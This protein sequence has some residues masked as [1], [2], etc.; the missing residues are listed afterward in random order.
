M[1]DVTTDMWHQYTD[2][3]ASPRF[4]AF[5]FGLD[6]IGFVGCGE[7]VA[8]TY[9]DTWWFNPRMTTTTA[10]GIAETK[11]NALQFNYNSQLSAFQIRGL[12]NQ[13]T[14][15][16]TLYTSGGQQVYSTRVHN[17]DQFEL[18]TSEFASGVYLLNAS[19]GNANKA[20]R[21]VR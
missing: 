21:F 17:T 10:V 5:G 9:N 18:S 16:L 3:P 13:Q 1:Y 19:N 14:W 11:M 8:A 2:L 20:F 12:S 4:R 6:T 15:T 7:S